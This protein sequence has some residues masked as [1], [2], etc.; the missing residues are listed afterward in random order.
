MR[1]ELGLVLSSADGLDPLC[2]PSVLVST[3]GARDL[4]ICD[5]AYQD[6]VERVLRLVRDRGAPLSANEVFPDK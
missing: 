5:V 4:A 6:M 1:E 3:L 2:H